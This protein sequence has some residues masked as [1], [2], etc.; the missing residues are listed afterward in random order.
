MVPTRSQ[1]SSKKGLIILEIYIFG[2]AA[3][4]KVLRAPALL[5]LRPCQTFSLENVLKSN[6]S[7]TAIKNY[8]FL[9][10]LQIFFRVFFFL[11]VG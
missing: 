3:A 10:H 7:Q 1:F 11:A 2:V 9:K 8:V 6:F 4:N 5:G